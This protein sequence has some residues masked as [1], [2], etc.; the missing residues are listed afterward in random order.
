[1]AATSQKP[2]YSQDRLDLARQKV[3]HR[4]YASGEDPRGFVEQVAV[5]WKVAC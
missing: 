1:V 2:E 5:G 4:L 3:G